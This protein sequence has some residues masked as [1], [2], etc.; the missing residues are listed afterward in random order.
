MAEDPS[1]NAGKERP[2]AVSADDL[3]AG[4]VGQTPEREPLGLTIPELAPEL[5]ACSSQE[6][7]ASLL[8][9]TFGD[10]ELLG[11]LGRGGMGIVYRARQKSLDRLVALK[12]V[13]RGQL[14]SDDDVRRFRKEAETA[15]TLDHPSIVPLY[16]VGEVHPE[17][18][19]PPIH[20]F[21]MKL[22]DGSSL[23]DSLG[24]YRN[25][26]QA[27]ARLVVTVARAVHHAHQR[28]ILHRDL[29][30]GNILL[31]GQRQPHITDFGLAKRLT[32][33]TALS[34]SGAII[35]SPEY[36][37][38]EQATAQKVLTT[39]ADIYA[40][41]AVLYALL[42]G[43]PPAQGN[44]LLETLHQVVA[45]EPTPPRRLNPATPRD[46]EVICLKCLQKS[47]SQRFGS[48]LELAE[49][50]E[51][52]LAG[53]V[54][55]ARPAGVAE[56]VAKW[57][58]RRPGVALLAGLCGAALL[59][60]VVGWAVF[61]VRLDEQRAA[62]EEQRLAADALRE[63]AEERKRDAERELGRALR[64]EAETK[65]QLELYRRSLFTSKLLQAAKLAETEPQA[66]REALE[67]GTAFPLDL[68]DFAWG[69][70][71]RLCQRDRPVLMPS[72]DRFAL[73]A[74]TP[75]GH[76]AAVFTQNRGQLRVFDLETGQLR[77]QVPA[78]GLA[79]PSG[80][81]QPLALSPD[82]A[83]LAT[84]Q[85]FGPS[86]KPVAIFSLWDTATGLR[87][88]SLEWDTWIGRAVAFSPDGKIVAVGRENGEKKAEIVLWNTASGKEKDSFAF[89]EGPVTR[90]LF[91]PDGAGLAAGYEDGS[92]QLLD[93]ATGKPRITLQR[94]WNPKPS[95]G[96]GPSVS[97]LAVSPDGSLLASGYANRGG[98]YLWDLATGKERTALD[99]P[100]TY[101]DVAFSHDGRLLAAGQRNVHVW[102]TRTGQDRLLLRRGHR[103]S[104]AFSADDRML[105]LGDGTGLV[106]WELAFAPERVAVRR[107]DVNLRAL[108]VLP[109]GRTVA[110]GHA[111][112][113]GLIWDAVSGKDQA[114]LQPLP[115]NA[116]YCLTLSAD[117]RFAASA[118]Q[119]EQGGGDVRLWDAATGRQLAVLA[120]HATAVHA[121][122]FSPDSRLLATVA[123]TTTA[124]LTGG[125]KDNNHIAKIRLWEVPTGREHLTLNV[126]TRT[127]PANGLAFSADGRTLA[128]AVLDISDPKKE[129]WQFHLWDLPSGRER[130]VLSDNTRQ[131]HRVVLALSPDGK[132]LAQAQG[133]QIQLWDVVGG[134]ARAEMRPPS[135]EEVTALVFSPDGQTLAA[136]SRHRTGTAY[137]S[138][139][140]VWDVAT[141]QERAVL[142]QHLGHPMA[143]AFAPDGQTLVSGSWAPEAKVRSEIKWWDGSTNPA[144]LSLRSQRGE[145]TGVA[146]LNSGNVLASMS[147]YQG[148]AE[149]R[150]WDRT[151]GKEKAVLKPRH[152]GGWMP[153]AG[154]ANGDLLAAGTVEHKG[155]GKYVGHLTL[156]DTATGAER[157]ALS[158]DHMLRSAVFSPDAELLA[159]GR[160]D[161]MVHLWEVATARERLA[162]R[163]GEGDILS[164]AFSPDGRVLASADFSTGGEPRRVQGLCFSADGRLLASGGG[165]GVVLVWDVATGE[166]RRLGGSP[167]RIGGLA[168]LPG[169][170]TLAAAS[171][172]EAGMSEVALW[173]LETGKARSLARGMLKLPLSL[174]VSADGKT[175]AAR[176]EDHSLLLWDLR[177]GLI[178]HGSDPTRP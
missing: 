89:A 126:P 117:G 151:A 172:D 173:D 77:C 43:R 153:L 44:N 91:L 52:W 61:T 132:T 23:A 166:H 94:E 121:V 53:E 20:F 103:G 124:D 33:D 136:L 11:E 98:V 85:K 167:V 134:G 81:T 27:A 115:L 159:A 156:W 58:R 107:A 131:P 67:D 93:P 106:R 37:A 66:A 51:R 16:E 9:P 108:H 21:S 7:A 69:F 18:G 71:Y 46:L 127:T 56:R 57:V 62:A 73:Q 35:G 92:I 83:L 125:K 26:P 32:G 28:G 17:D 105:T 118:G 86:Q 177:R 87:R 14:A 76:T 3:Q 63:L 36:M 174:S 157:A 5:R 123:G 99:I 59:V 104:L 54:I 112:N 119:T 100:E 137:V 145:V 138:L 164:L 161:G 168:W 176:I 102:D 155:Q 130:A 144:R 60:L 175:L 171:V 48:A 41:G 8:P 72:L 129:Q 111:Q 40:L 74:L 97:S 114:R 141:G 146:L 95:P 178:G 158:H 68:R 142:K 133:D 154:T 152:S 135:A 38:P 10:Y 96:Q 149:V 78:G 140:T 22:V 50:L 170:R 42:T 84:L 15:G 113:S 34:H 169:D 64:S 47:P 148:G 30:P 101:C 162:F 6:Q 24:Q 19:G 139:V 79:A 122:A 31:D 116:C 80:G 65:R 13:L 4:A 128:A 165:D 49:D 109:D 39:G 1:E 75:D 163:A 2:S 120:D 143:L 150:L 55:Q 147:E 45:A 70:H 110:L 29:K 82:G 160:A 88:N 90:L 25:D 12:V